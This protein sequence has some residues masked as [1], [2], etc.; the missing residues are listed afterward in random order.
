MSDCPNEVSCCPPQLY[1]VVPPPAFTSLSGLLW[2]LPCP[3]NTDPGTGGC[4][5]PGPPDQVTSLSG[6]PGQTYSVTLLFR[7]IMESAEHTGGAVV[8]VNPDL[9]FQLFS[10]TTN[11]ASPGSPIYQGGAHTNDGSN[12]YYLSISNPPA[13]YFLNHWQAGYEGSYNQVLAY[14]YA[15]TVPMVTGAIITL[16]C[17]D[18]GDGSETIN[19][20]NPAIMNVLAAVSTTYTGAGFN[21]PAVNGTATIAVA[22]TANLVV[23]NLIQIGGFPLVLTA[24][25]SGTITVSNLMS[26]NAGLPVANGAAVVYGGEPLLNVTQDPTHGYGYWGQFCQV[27]VLSIV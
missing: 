4:Q 12:V 10:G 21:V 1:Q 27:D 15:L 11:Y 13:L 14:R 2:Q 3:S 23:P 17:D 26:A 6:V 8:A 20:P 5:C 25:G 18:G 16:H 24:I 19:Y 9:P 7:G 22:S